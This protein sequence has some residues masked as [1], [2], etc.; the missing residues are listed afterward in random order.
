MLLSIHYHYINIENDPFWYNDIP[1]AIDFCMEGRSTLEEL[2][3]K[4]ES[5]PCRQYLLL[6]EMEK[7]TH[8]NQVFCYLHI[9]FSSYYFAQERGF[10]Q[11]SNFIQETIIKSIIEAFRKVKEELSVPSVSVKSYLHSNHK[12]YRS[13]VKQQLP[14]LTPFGTRDYEYDKYLLGRKAKRMLNAKN[15]TGSATEQ[16][17]ED[18]SVCLR[19]PPKF[20]P[21]TVPHAP[22]SAASPQ[23]FF[24]SQYDQSDEQVVMPLPYIINPRINRYQQAP[25]QP[26]PAPAPAQ[27]LAPAPEPTTAPAQH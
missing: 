7:I 6:H 11:T 5:C 13:Y 4:L 8:E 22:V 1:I 21:E 19:D 14:L 12:A 9:S 2:K 10:K 18:G 26:Q 17:R 15:E 3:N 20:T 16:P 23:T 24:G 27:P 25:A